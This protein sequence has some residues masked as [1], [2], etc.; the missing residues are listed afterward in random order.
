VYEVTEYTEFV[1]FDRLKRKIRGCSLINSITETR[2]E[3]LACLK[4]KSLSNK[5]KKVL[6][7]WTVIYNFRFM[8]LGW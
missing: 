2:K 3:K 8:F 6:K 4:L 5:A 7:D 1:A